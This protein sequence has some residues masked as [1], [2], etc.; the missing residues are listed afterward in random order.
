MVQNGS[1]RGAI[2]LLTTAYTKPLKP[3][4]LVE[5]VRGEKW[6]TCLEVLRQKHPQAALL[7]KESVS[8]EDLPV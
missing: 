6:E 2:A 1:V 3:D 8:M 7:Y 4:D 5:T